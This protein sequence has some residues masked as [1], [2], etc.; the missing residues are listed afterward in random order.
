MK[1]LA[2]VTRLLPV[3]DRPRYAAEF[4]AE[5][6][7]IAAVGDGRRAQICYATRLVLT[8]PR[9]RFEL[10]APRRRSAAQ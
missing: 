4:R 8:A 10:E 2:T 3:A 7:D 5:L 1:L 6:A 9:L